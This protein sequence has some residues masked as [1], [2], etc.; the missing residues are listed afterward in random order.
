MERK[1]HHGFTFIEV[2]I[3]VMIIGLLVSFALPQYQRY[4]QKTNR[5]EAMAYLQRMLDAQE[6]YY[7]DHRTY[8]LDLN[9]VSQGLATEI[10]QTSLYTYHFEVCEN[11]NGL[12][13]C[14][15]AV[16]QP[17]PLGLQKDDG[18]LSQSSRGERHHDTRA[19]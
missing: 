12:K 8:H 1:N 15:L 16:A 9:T 13:E 6:R 5:T 4:A 18:N 11:S 3:V 10:D 2:I 14:I 7:M 19:E 17:N